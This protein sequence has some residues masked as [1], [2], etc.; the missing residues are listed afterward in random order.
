MNCIRTTSSASWLRHLRSLY[1][2][3]W[4]DRGLLIE[5]AALLGAARLAAKTIPFKQLARCFGQ[6]MSESERVVESGVDARA[7]RIGWAVRTVARRTPWNSNCLAQAVAARLML[8]R[9][10]MACT[11][12]LGLVKDG[13]HELAA[14]AWLRCGNR[15]VT[16]GRTSSRRYTVVSTFS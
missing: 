12:Y 6:H 11:V 15:V 4:S 10:K 16:G 14:H 1:D 8:R 13:K 9:R 2:L 7:S 3:A 5:A